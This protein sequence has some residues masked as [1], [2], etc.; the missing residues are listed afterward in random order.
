M[1]RVTP[2]A[3]P[4]RRGLRG[5]IAIAALASVAIG[6]AWTGLGWLESARTR[7]A[8]A[9]LFDGR[10]PMVARI[11]G[12]ADPMPAGVVACANCHRPVAPPADARPEPA[13]PATTAAA[14]AAV[15]STAVASTAGP[16]LGRDL[17]T[18][19]LP[20]RGGPP[21]RYDAAAFCRVLRTGEDPAGVLLPRAMPRYEID[22]AAC[23]ALWRFL[24]AS[25]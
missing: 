16:V 24:N 12:H 15:A 9:R 8:G 11:S 25:P 7:D 1:L 5:P 18:R 23:D 21:S 20:R 13:A 3:P 22:A 6:L 17:L 2:P 19:P 10:T 14:P 4:P